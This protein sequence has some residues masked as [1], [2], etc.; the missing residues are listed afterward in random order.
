M[1]SGM[2]RRQ[3]K[4]LDKSQLSPLKAEVVSAPRHWVQICILVLGGLLCHGIILINC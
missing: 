1:N 4:T 2:S 3:K